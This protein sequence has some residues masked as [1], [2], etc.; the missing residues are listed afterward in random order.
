VSDGGVVSDGGGLPVPLSAR[1]GEY[2]G[3]EGAPCMSTCP[4]AIAWR[5]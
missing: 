5:R 1:M 4:C 2:G 3:E